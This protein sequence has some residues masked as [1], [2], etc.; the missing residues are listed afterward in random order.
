MGPIRHSFAH[1]S[2]FTTQSDYSTAVK[3]LHCSITEDTLIQLVQYSLDQK[4]SLSDL[5]TTS[6]LNSA[7]TE[8]DDKVCDLH[9]QPID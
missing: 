4:R 7:P 3:L 8:I 6:S 5:A 2:K 9:C 1:I